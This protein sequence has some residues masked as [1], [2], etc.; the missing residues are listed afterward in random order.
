MSLASGGDQIDEP[1]N[2]DHISKNKNE[3]TTSYHCPCMYGSA[4]V[5]SP[6]IDMAGIIS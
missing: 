6:P 3:K 1:T 2:Q 5:I 4:W